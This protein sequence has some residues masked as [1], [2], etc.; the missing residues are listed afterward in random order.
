LVSHVCSLLIYNYN[1]PTDNKSFVLFS[2]SNIA[3]VC[4]ISIPD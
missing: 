3:F 1:I 2:L 4:V